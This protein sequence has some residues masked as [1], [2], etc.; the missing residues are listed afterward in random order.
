MLQLTAP[1]SGELTR[2][3][4][5]Y[6][7]AKA[8]DGALARQTLTAAEEEAANG[9]P[10]DQRR[11]DYRAGRL[12]A[13]RAL[14]RLA[15]RDAAASGAR[16]VVSVAHV[17][18]RAIAAAAPGNVRVGVD[19]ERSHRVS[20]REGRLFLTHAELGVRVADVTVL[21]ALK[22]AAWKALLLPPSVPFHDLELTFGGAGRLTAVRLY[23]Q[24]LP[25]SADVLRPWPDHVATVVWLEDDL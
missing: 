24:C 22:E 11:R 21:W 9:F 6:V 14:A 4:A 19:L 17:A 18:G 13:R 2:R 1:T 12:A 25:A 5:R 23:G 8:V 15:E 7:V 10:S 20:P 16:P 3:R